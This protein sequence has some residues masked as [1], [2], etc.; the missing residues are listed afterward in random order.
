MMPRRRYE[1]HGWGPEGKCFAIGSEWR[2]TC[3]LHFGHEGDCEYEAI[4]APLATVMLLPNGQVSAK[5]AQCDDQAPDILT[6]YRL[7]HP[8][9]P[10]DPITDMP[11]W[12]HP[13]WDGLL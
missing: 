8:D 13:K 3:V 9:K 12:D 7:A 1:G 4:A 11:E 6:H 5:C 2:K 10:V